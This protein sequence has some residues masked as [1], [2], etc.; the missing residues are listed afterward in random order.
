M[1]LSY[2]LRTISGRRSP[3]CKGPFTSNESEKDERKIKM[4]KEA[5]DRNQRKFSLH[6]VWMVLKDANLKS[7]CRIIGDRCNHRIKIPI[8]RHQLFGTNVWTLGVLTS[9]HDFSGQWHYL[10]SSAYVSAMLL[11]LLRHIFVVLRCQKKYIIFQYT[12]P[13]VYWI[14]V[15][16]VDLYKWMGICIK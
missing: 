10:M 7:Q 4:I 15:P 14:S 16:K 2:E 3:L 6:S 11:T 1:I 5:F 12:Y 13:H 8:S 9:L